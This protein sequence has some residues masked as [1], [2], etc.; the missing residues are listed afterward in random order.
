MLLYLL[1]PVATSFNLFSSPTATKEWLKKPENF[2]APE[3]KPLQV[4]RGQYGDLITGTLALGFRL[5]T[6]V[7]VLGW[8]PVGIE[9]GPLKFGK[10]L[11]KDEYALR[12]GPVAY[13]DESSVELKEPKEPLIL[14]EYESSPFCR[15]VREAACVLDL[16]MEMRPCPG[17]RKGFAD[18]LKA[19]GGKFTVPYLAD[20]NTG[21]EMYESED[22]L[23][24][25]LKTY[26]D[27]TTYDPKALWPLRGQ[28]AL[29]TGA[30][31]ALA[32]GFPCTKVL[33]GAR[34]DNVDVMPLKLY[35]YEPSPFVRSVRETLCGLALPHVVIP[36]ARGSRHRDRLV[37]LTN[38]QFQVPYLEDP[39]T[40]VSLFESPEILDYLREVYT[41]DSDSK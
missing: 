15:K 30:F 27:P 29:W 10:D 32:R 11:Q 5:A 38:T 36:T 23:D 33:S 3:P 25:L 17:A 28:F 22:I 24:Y 21:T 1:L 16:P 41:T 2:E 18:E 13:R 12:L 8:R 7:F 34:P 6:G 20:P 39:N 26:T 19:R 14:Y 40:G 37:Q 4:T 9:L 35:G 31:A